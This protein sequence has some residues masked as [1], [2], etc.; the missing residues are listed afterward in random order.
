L[1]LS[2]GVSLTNWKLQLWAKDVLSNGISSGIKVAEV[3]LDGAQ[4]NGGVARLETRLDAT[5][6]PTGRYYDMALVLAGDD[7]DA[8]IEVANYSERQWITGPFLQ[9]AVGYSVNEGLVTINVEQVCNPRTD[10]NLS[11]TLALELWATAEPYVGGAVRGHQ[12]AGVELG[13]QAGETYR[14]D[15]AA[16]LDFV[17]PPAGQWQVVLMLREWTA[18]GYVTRDYRTFD[19]CYRV[20]A[21]SADA[22]KLPSA[23]AASAVEAL[24]A[25][26]TAVQPTAAP[27]AAVQP[28]AA[29]AVAARPVAVAVQPVAAQPAAAQAVAVAVRP[30]AVQP[31]AVQPVAAQAAPAQPAAIQPKVVVQVTTAAPAPVEAIAVKPAVEDKRISVQTASVEELAQ[32]KGI[33]KKLAQEIVRAR[34]YKALNELTRVKGLGEKTLRL[35]RDAIKV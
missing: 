31:A 6:P 14:T 20:P 11:G 21:T 30:A 28:V 3:A 19:A 26:Q 32:V 10:G 17:A 12:L 2:E 16:Q 9:G 23:L 5:L 29:P 15:V 35:L 18:A 33:S 27:P 7:A 25:V 22:A 4:V 8:P 1:L 34:P 13:T 24:S